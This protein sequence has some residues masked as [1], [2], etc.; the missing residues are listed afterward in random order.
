VW[1]TGVGDRN[2]RQK[3]TNFPFPLQKIQ[4]GLL[5]GVSKKYLGIFQNQKEQKLEKLLFLFIAI[6]FGVSK[7]I[8]EINKNYHFSSE[9]S[10]SQT[11]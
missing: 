5:E 8:L 2:S 10:L 7:T 9:Q 11:Y 3:K 6:R 4:Y 1:T